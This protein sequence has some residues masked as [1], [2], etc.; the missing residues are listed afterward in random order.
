MN[1]AATGNAKLDYVLRLGDNA[2]VLGQ[3]LGEWVG[4]GPELEEEM[5]MANFALDY[6]GHA[7]HFY[8]LAGEIEGAGKSED[9][10]A[11]LRDGFDFQNALLVE[12]PNGHFGDTIARQ[13][14][15]ERFYVLQLDALTQSTDARLAA[16]ATRAGKEI[17][18]HLRHARQWLM[19]LGDGTAQSHERIQNSIDSLWRYT[20][21]LFSADAV[22]AEVA[23]SGFG[24]D[25]GKL[26]A[27]WHDDVAADLKE[28]TLT[29]PDTGWMASGGKQGR[30]SEHLGYLLADL[31]FLQRAYPQQ[32]W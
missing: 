1:S 18:Y 6:I 5:A 15:F 20:G 16:I 31:Q 12:Q 30:H 2:L 3:R 19:R 24:I 13:Y 23:A 26:E 21:E 32:Q 7:R 25:P 8:S 28:A 4:A 11:Y 29:L 9:D 10:Y 14:L 22:E 17:R 27:R